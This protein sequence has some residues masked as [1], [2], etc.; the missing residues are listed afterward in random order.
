VLSFPVETSA[1]KSLRGEKSPSPRN[2][3]Q[4][5]PHAR[6][7]P[8]RSEILVLHGLLHLRGYDHECDNGQ[9]G[10]RKNSCARIHLP[11]D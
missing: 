1:A 5:R 8:A 9:I 6:H 10:S 4:E 11:L 2:R 7:S 3:I